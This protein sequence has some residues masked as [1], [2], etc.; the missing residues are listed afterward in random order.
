MWKVLT[1]PGRIEK[2]EYLVAHNLTKY[3]NTKKGIDRL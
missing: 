3:Y 2:T 1:M